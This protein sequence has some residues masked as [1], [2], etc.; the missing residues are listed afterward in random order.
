[1]TKNATSEMTISVPDRIAHRHERS[2]KSKLRALV[3]EV[4]TGGAGASA[5]R[6]APAVVTPSPPA[7]RGRRRCRPPGMRT[8]AR[9]ARHERHERVHEE[10]GD[11]QVEDRREPEEEREAL[12]PS[13]WRAT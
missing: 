13:R 6:A 11:E 1:M 5:R 3:V 9:R 7:R 4:A 2:M 12:A 8:S 10:V